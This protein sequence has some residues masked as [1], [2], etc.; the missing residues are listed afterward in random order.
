MKN[1]NILRFGLGLLFAIAALGIWTYLEH[2]ILLKW[3][4][5]TARFIGRPISSTVY[6]NGKT[7]DKIE[8]FEVD[9]RRSNKP[10]KYYLIHFLYAD[11][12]ETRKIICVSQQNDFVGR[13]SGSNKDDY[14]MV[15]GNLFQSEVGGKFNS[16]KDDMKG[17]D[18]DPQLM[19]TESQFTLKIP[20]SA[21]EYQCD[22]LRVVIRT[23]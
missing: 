21:T 4:T 18:F 12:D 19:F 3:V 23:Q 11:T 2:P 10:P 7:N 5:G 6:T 13:P 22:S 9:G 17:Y 1:R 14:P 15:F 16:F 8:V 20:P